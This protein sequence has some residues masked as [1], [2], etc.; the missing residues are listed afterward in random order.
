MHRYSISFLL[1]FK[2]YRDKTPEIENALRTLQELLC[3]STENVEKKP[4]FFRHSNRRHEAPRILKATLMPTKTGVSK[5]LGILNKLGPENV[6]ASASTLL[7]IIQESECPD[8]VVETLCTKSLDQDV[9]VAP[10]FADLWLSLINLHPRVKPLYMKVAKARFDV[11]E[12]IVKL[13]AAMT[14]LAR[15][16]IISRQP[17]VQL[18]DAFISKLPVNH[19]CADALLLV[20]LLDPQMVHDRSSLVA[21]EDRLVLFRR[22]LKMTSDEFMPLFATVCNSWPSLPENPL[23]TG[24]AVPVNALQ[25]ITRL[26]VSHSAFQTFANGVL[27]ALSDENRSPNADVVYTEI[28]TLLIILKARKVSGMLR[29]E[30]LRYAEQNAANKAIPARS[31]FKLMD[32]VDTKKLG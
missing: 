21:S 15:R 29:A 20:H 9:I 25:L 31:R 30:I 3:H 4:R 23:V 6:L 19:T 14:E 13:T 12:D 26:K 27:D 22:L 28:M 8:T 10:L 1:S 16:G 7:Q 11:F 17:I 18:T 32:I 2:D 24:T 5:I